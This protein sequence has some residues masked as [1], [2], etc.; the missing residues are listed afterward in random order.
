MNDCTYHYSRLLHDKLA[1]EPHGTD[2]VYCLTINSQ[3]FFVGHSTDIEQHLADLVASAVHTDKPLLNE[4]AQFLRD[5][6]KHGSMRIEVE[7]LN[8][9]EMTDPWNAVDQVAEYVKIFRDDDHPLVNRD[10]NAEPVLAPTPKARKVRSV[11][12]GGTEKA[13][14]VPR[15]NKGGGWGVNYDEYGKGL[16]VRTKS[17]IDGVFW[18]A[19]QDQLIDAINTSLLAKGKVPI[20][21]TKKRY[22]ASA[23]VRKPLFQ[24]EA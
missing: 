18:T 11:T 3:V 14:R 23:G 8:S 10:P 6:L 4:A 21:P 2:V 1:S 20:G 12:S 19:N 7:H 16:I 5:R 15:P 17:P 22:G 13:P 9:S 24:P